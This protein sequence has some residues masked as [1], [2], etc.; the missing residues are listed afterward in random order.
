MVLYTNQLSGSSLY[1]PVGHTLGD[2][3]WYSELY[4]DNNITYFDVVT[5]KA[6]GSVRSSNNI[7]PTSSGQAPKYYY[8]DNSS[9]TINSGYIFRIMV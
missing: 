7:Q 1:L 9:R 6:S 2:N 8:S 4:I 5:I 3:Y